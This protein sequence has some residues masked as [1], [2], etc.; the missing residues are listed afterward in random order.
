[1]RHHGWL[2]GDDNERRNWLL[3][4]AETHSHGRSRV[5]EPAEMTAHIVRIPDDIVARERQ[6]ARTRLR[7]GRTKSGLN[8]KNL[9]T[10]VNV[11]DLQPYLL[12]CGGLRGYAPGSTLKL[13]E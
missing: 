5:V 13:L 2:L 10:Q 11:V 6:A 3:H 1:M 7:I 12:S 4:R 8:S 9:S